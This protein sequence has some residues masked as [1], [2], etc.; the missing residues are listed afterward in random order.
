[1]AKVTRSLSSKTDANGKS[2]ILI[3]LNVSRTKQIRL[4]SNI[5]IAPSRINKDGDIV[6]P[7]IK[8]RDYH[9]V[10]MIFKELQQLE[11]MLTDL[12]VNERE[13]F[14]T[15]EYFQT[16]I[17]LFHNAFLY[18]G[19][20]NDNLCSREAETMTTKAKKSVAQT[21][22]IPATKTI[23][24]MMNPAAEGFDN[25]Q[26]IFDVFK[27]YMVNKNVSEV[28]KARYKVVYRSLYRYEQYL[29]LLKGRK[30]CLS[31]QSFSVEDA[32]DFEKFLRE[33][34]ELYK[35]YP[36]LYAD[37]PL[38][39][40]SQ[41][42]LPKP[43]ERGDNIIVS[44]L[45]CLR[46]FF[47]YCMSK[48]YIVK[49]PFLGFDGTISERYGTPY[50]IT[51]EERDII[52][53]FEIKNKALAAQRDIFIF[54]T[55]IGCRVSDMMRLTPDDIIN[56]VVEYIPQKTM[57]DRAKVVRVPLNQRGLD[58]L[59]KYKGVDS[60]GRILPFIST[61]KYNDA[62]K[63]IFEQCNITR[64]VTV[65]DP[66]SGKETKRPINELASSHMARRTFVGNLYKKVKDPNLVGALS[67]HAEGSKAFARYREI[68][69]D[70]KRELIGYLD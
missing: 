39:E 65:I 10:S 40:G 50:Y 21:A 48:S 59:A 4:R 33:E 35:K 12:C 32:K 31:L 53:D 27:E 11:V 18:N 52:A 54:Q 45:R 66:V 68:D 2:E 20:S 6:M 22:S 64:M 37:D 28:R 9:E 30:F 8:S 5:F 44:L 34:H 70:I 13:E 57:H 46:A 25:K 7:R 61:Q 69:D 58:I 67:G 41:R 24:D 14:L 26:S 43:V 23:H 62:I 49:D 56:G 1:M 60:K 38:N 51:I 15:K 47:H 17:N 19:G 16:Q 36:K 55:L 3:R 42:K 63:K 29:K